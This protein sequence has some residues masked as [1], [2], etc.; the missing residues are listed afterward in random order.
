MAELYPSSLQES[1][2]RGSFTRVTGNN[3]IFSETDF[4]PSKTRRRTTLRKDTIQGEIIL[5]DNDEYSDFINF[6][7]TTLKDGTL[8]F[9]F[10]DPITYNDIEVRFKEG[11]WQL[12]DIGYRTYAVSMT[13]EVVSE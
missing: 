4:G 7:T 1:F 11:G 2:T 12:K 8:S 6:Y 3:V 13:L 10:K 9:L 5:K